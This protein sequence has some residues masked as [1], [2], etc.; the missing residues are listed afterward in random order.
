MQRAKPGFVERESKH[1][2]LEHEVT[3]AADEAGLVGEGEG[4]A[5]ERRR[6]RR[7]VVRRRRDVREAG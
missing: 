1:R 6:A 4:G 2:R 3:E 7:Q 5:A